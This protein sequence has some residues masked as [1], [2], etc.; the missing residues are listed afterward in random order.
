ME[1]TVYADI[2]FAVNFSMD[3]LALYITAFIVKNKFHLS[4]GIAAAAVGGAYGVLAVVINT[5]MFLTIV[6]TL[7]YA[8]IMCLILSGFADTM[9]FIR[10][11]LVFL[12]AN[13][14][15]GGGMTAI[16]NWFNSSGAAQ[17][18]LIYGELGSVE[19]QMPLT[20][21]AIGGAALAVIMLLFGRSFVNKRKLHTAILSIRY[22][23]NSINTHGIVDSGNLLTEP[24][25]GQSVIF[26]NKMLANE[27]LSR[28]M[29]ELL[30]DMRAKAVTYPVG[31]IRFLVCDT[32]GGPKTVGAFKPDVVKINGREVAAWIAVVDSGEMG[33]EG[34]LS[35]IIPAEFTGA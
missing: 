24:F 17:K 18:L 31:R 33:G 14:A 23:A 4:R 1:Q 30:A 22:G 5:G 7:I 26:I 32:V 34:S 3:F 29:A 21:F 25:S 10:K 35:A 8:I 15:I 9:S 16:Y 28:E 12:V 13:L 11:L 6:F 19:E 27:L 20:L 2:L